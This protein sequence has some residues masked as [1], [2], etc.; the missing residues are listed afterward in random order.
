MNEKNK[1]PYSPCS[2]DLAKDNEARLQRRDID[3]QSTSR[4]Q[5]TLH[6]VLQHS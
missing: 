1:V 4:E 6:L 2:I 3:Q 5:D